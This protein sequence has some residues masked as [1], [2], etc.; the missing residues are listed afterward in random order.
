MTTKKSYGAKTNDTALLVSSSPL[1]RLF[2]IGNVIS[3]YI[4]RADIRVMFFKLWSSS[5]GGDSDNDPGDDKSSSEV[6]KHS[7]TSSRMSGSLRELKSMAHGSG[8]IS[9][10]TLPRAG[11]SSSHGGKRTVLILR[12]RVE[13]SDGR[14]S[15][16]T[17]LNIVITCR[18]GLLL[19]RGNQVKTWLNIP[20]S[21]TTFTSAPI[22]CDKKAMD[23]LPLPRHNIMN[24]LPKP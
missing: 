14:S 21:S 2:E 8:G 1:A 23:Q 17:R 5:G 7:R 16:F 11:P 22:F 10:S 6:Y 19:S 15:T 3:N 12:A 9:W 24:D 13:S 20:C 18:T 4:L